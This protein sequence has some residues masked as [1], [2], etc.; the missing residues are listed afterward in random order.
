MLLEILAVVFNT[1]DTRSV[2]LL[3][4]SNK[5]SA[6]TISLKAFIRILVT[7]HCNFGS[8]RNSVTIS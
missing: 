4:S 1:A 5:L 6:S 7:I 2:D 8:R 3:S